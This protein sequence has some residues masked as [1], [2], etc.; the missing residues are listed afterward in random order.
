[1]FARIKGFGLIQRSP[2]LSAQALKTRQGP[3]EVGSCSLAQK[4]RGSLLWKELIPLV[5]FFA[6][7]DAQDQMPA[8]P[9]DAT[10]SN[11]LIRQYFPWKTDLFGCTRSKP[12]Q[13]RVPADLT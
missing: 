12:S 2:I 13:G 10:P 1:V 5:L 4:P 3:T 11:R 8:Q 7:R 6:I 9:V